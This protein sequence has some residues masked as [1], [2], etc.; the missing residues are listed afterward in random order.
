MLLPRFFFG[1]LVYTPSMMARHFLAMSSG[2]TIFPVSPSTPKSPALFI[3]SLNA[4]SSNT[5]LGLLDG[6]VFILKE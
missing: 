2:L 5:M 1:A 4:C 3:A 6:F